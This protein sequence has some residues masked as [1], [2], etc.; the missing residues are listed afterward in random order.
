[1]QGNRAIVS[2]LRSANGTFINGIRVRFPTPM[3]PGDRIDIGPYSLLFTGDALVQQSRENNVELIGRHLQRVVTDRSTGKPRYLLDDI[4]LV[5]R[6]HEF[7]CLLGPSGSGKTT[8]LSALSGRVPADGVVMLN[9]KDLYGNFESLKRDLVVVA[10][11]DVLHESLSVERAIWYTAKLRLPPDTRNTEIHSYIDEMLGTVGLTAHRAT[12]IYALSGGQIKRTSLANELLSKPTLLF[13]DEVTSGLDEQTDREMMQLFRSLADAGKTVV[14]VTHSLA[15]V[16]QF[17]H[18]V[19]ILA[20]GGKLAFMGKPAEALQYFGI[21]RL[22]DVYEK[23]SERPAQEWQDAFARSAYHAHYIAGR[24]PPGELG[25]EAV[26]T[27]RVRVSERARSIVRQ[28]I[29]LTRRYLDITV[30]DYRALAV[31]FGQA[32]L[33]AAVLVILLGNM[34]T[35]KTTVYEHTK[36]SLILVFLLQI[37]CFWFG[38]NN[39]A[40]EIV[41]ERVIY[42]RERD[43]NLNISSYYVSKFVLLTLLTVLQ[44]A[45]LWSIVQVLCK[46]PGDMARTLVFLATMGMAGVALGLAASAVATSSDVAAS[47]IPIALIP[48]I[49]LAGAIIELK[50]IAERLAKGLITCYWGN[51]GLRALLPENVLDHAPQVDRYPPWKSYGVVV[52][53]MAV[54]I[55]VGVVVLVWQDR[56]ARRTSGGARL[57]RKGKGGP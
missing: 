33:V 50:D 10:Q 57:L 36:N 23:L 21:N 14:C 26:S 20:Q 52:I 19:V 40:K 16:E 37:S 7:V 47:L 18:L 48:Q 13:L 34:E 5:I 17:C 51:R 3:R 53:H 2:D 45:L 32:L 8:L 1:M 30:A 41:K 28:S 49:I 15:N 11:K 44:V 27:T 25:N 35:T 12:P 42:S 31:M 22:G 6:P 54:F 43:F 24:L 39:A 9:G 55:V 38:C 29:L 56:R 4:T 46:P